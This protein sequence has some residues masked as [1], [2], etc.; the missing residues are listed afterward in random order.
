MNTHSRVGLLALS[1][2]FLFATKSIGAAASLAVADDSIVPH[3]T[4][5]PPPTPLDVV[6]NAQL[7]A[8]C[9]TAITTKRY[10]TTVPKL[11]RQLTFTKNILK[12][13]VRLM[14]ATVPIELRGL[15]YITD[16]IK[17]RS[18]WFEL[19]PRSPIANDKVLS[20]C[21]TRL[22]S[23]RKI[24]KTLQELQKF[25]QEFGYI[26]VPS[27]EPPSLTDKI[28][29]QYKRL[30]CMR[31]IVKFLPNKVPAITHD[32]Y[33]RLVAEQRTDDKGNLLG[34]EFGTV[35]NMPDHCPM[36]TA[37]LQKNFKLFTSKAVALTTLKQA[38]ERL[39]KLL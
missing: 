20:T 19:Y 29:D 36:P 37:Q 25:L 11:P 14:H 26:Y 3:S 13:P 34:Y 21:L 38:K 22:S 12:C 30:K 24:N 32:R 28:R 7:S 16:R 8:A 5:L 10:A 1:I 9:S 31:R 35:F 33:R 39:A 4:I 27:Q 17:C 23:K 18:K 6:H 2:L 15:I